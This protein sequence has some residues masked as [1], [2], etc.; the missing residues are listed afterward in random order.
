MAVLRPFMAIRPRKDLVSKVAE[1]PYD[2][3]SRK[4]AKKMAAENPISFLHV[5]RAEID[6]DDNKNPYNIEIYEK[7]RENL[8]N[9]IEKNIL[10]KDKKRCLYIYR[11]VMGEK[12]QT[13]IVGCTAV[14]DYLNDVIKKHEFTRKEKEQDR[15][16]HIDFCDANTGPIFLTYRYDKNIGD[17]VDEWTKRIPE[18]DFIANDG[19]EHI[20]WV[21]DN[22]KI[23]RV[24]INLFKGIKNLYIADGHHRAASAVKIGLK[25]RNQNPGYD[26]NEEFNFFLSVIFPD[27]DLNILDYNRIVKDLN[28]LDVKEYIEKVAEKFN[29]EEYTLKGQYKPKC[30]HSYGMYLAGK[31][32]KL[33]PKVGSYDAHDVVKNL[34][35]SILQNNLLTPILSIGDPRTDKRIEFI[36][37]I[38]GLSELEERVNRNE[39]KVAFS[40][41]A[42][43]MQDLMNIADA[44]K[45][46]PPKSTWFEPKLRSGIFVHELK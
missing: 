34:D 19:V 16:N 25:R 33:K 21:I 5:D 18:Y 24:L 2:V 9:M 36:G 26:G 11:L 10:I 8:Y 41:Y 46:M 38:R 22:E 3:M 29:I 35:V 4:E 15:I 23:I 6:F 14:D 20:V 31:W 32:Y 45:V 7:A 43:Y 28:G 13:G 12:V 37:G 1:L 42:P 44:G 30:K 39:G 40:M 17:I 27:N